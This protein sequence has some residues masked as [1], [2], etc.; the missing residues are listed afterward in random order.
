[1]TLFR[2]VSSSHSYECR[3]WTA[4]TVPDKEEEEEEIRSL[5]TTGTT[6]SPLTRVESSV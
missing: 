6:A 5:E 4:R 3:S 1:M 2:W